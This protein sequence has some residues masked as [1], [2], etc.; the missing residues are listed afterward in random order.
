MGWNHLLYVW[1]EQRSLARTAGDV[2]I[3]IA[4]AIHRLRGGDARAIARAG[5]EITTAANHVRETAS[6]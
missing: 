1:A 3:L 6:V 4:K 5:G 2:M